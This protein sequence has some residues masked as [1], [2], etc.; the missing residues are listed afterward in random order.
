M[1]HDP[2]RLT[3]CIQM[4]RGVYFVLQHTSLRVLCC[5]LCPVPP[6]SQPLYV[7]GWGAGWGTRCFNIGIAGRQPLRCGICISTSQGAAC[8]DG[9]ASSTGLVLPYICVPQCR[10]FA[11]ECLLTEAHG[12][13]GAPKLRYTAPQPAMK[14]GT[15][16]L[17]TGE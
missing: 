3:G 14:W 17:K 8:R 2:S 4:S 7:L 11:E 16:C 13:S 6:G 12:D 10:D 9:E 15:L 5:G 1:L